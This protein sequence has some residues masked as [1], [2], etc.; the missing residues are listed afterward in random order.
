MSSN[1]QPKK[2][3]LCDQH[4]ALGG[5]MVDFAGYLM[6]VSYPK[7]IIAEHHA[8]RNNVGVFDVSHMGEFEVTGP[9]ALSWVN[10]MVTNDAEKLG[11]NQVMYSGLCY[12]DGGFVDD[13]LVY[14]LADKVMLV[15]N[16]S[17]IKKDFAWLKAHVPATGV[18]FVDKSDDFTLLAVQGPRA[19][20]LVQ[21]LTNVD[22]KQIKYYWCQPGKIA[23]IDGIVSRTGYTGEYGFELYFPVEHSLLV[24]NELWKYGKDFGL[25]PIGLGARDSLRL[26]MKLA[27]YG[28]E[29]DADHNPIEAGLS[30]IVKL[31]KPN[32][33]GRDSMLKAKLE[34]TPRFNVGF[35]VEGR[36]VPRPG[37]VIRCKDGETIGV[38]TS[39]TWSPTL[40]K[41]IGT[42]YVAMDDSP[43][44]T[45]IQIVIRDRVVKATVVKTPFV[46][47][48]QPKP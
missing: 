4:I 29:I 43:V 48:E 25:E 12:P 27:L 11:L 14:R 38:V 47:R 7:G 41:G 21:K 46:V 31:S 6:P 37:M 24:W 9:D 5:K 20:E 34:G 30:W 42:G 17:N 3:A 13:L 1:G 18:T 16:A 19:G 23:G 45:E 15:V 10:S 22:V 33:Y 26:E 39:G 28:H 2:L 36:A 8:V 44:G 32:F 35:M 40:D